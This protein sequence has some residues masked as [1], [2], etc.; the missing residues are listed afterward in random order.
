MKAVGDLEVEVNFSTDRT[1]A[2]EVKQDLVFS[3]GY[4]CDNSAKPVHEHDLGVG[5]GFA[6]VQTKAMTRADES[7]TSC[8]C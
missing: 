4:L 2:T 3:I 5:V 7:E 1:T 8:A 6:L